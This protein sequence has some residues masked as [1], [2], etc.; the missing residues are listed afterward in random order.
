MSA[1]NEPIAADVTML[2]GSGDTTDA[3][4]DELIVNKDD[5]RLKKALGLVRVM[6]SGNLKEQCV[7][8]EWSS[9]Q[10]ETERE[11]LVEAVSDA[12][13]WKEVKQ[14]TLADMDTMPDE[15]DEVDTES[16]LLQMFKCFDK[17][18]SGSIDSNELH[19][20]LLYMGISATEKEVLEMIAQVDKNGDGDIDESEFLQVMRDAQ[21]GQLAIAAPSRQSIR[22][23]S[24]RAQHHA[25]E[26][27]KPVGTPPPE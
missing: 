25:Q 4:V 23:A 11:L 21:A 2:D 22:R 6:S 8:T 27:S 20:M 19:Q 5:A 13:F 7:V 9:L 1:A 17:D 26:R 10:T 16:R 15:D 12:A 18:N 14:M 24:F 3:D